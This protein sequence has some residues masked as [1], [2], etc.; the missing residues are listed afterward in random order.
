MKY[1]EDV[2]CKEEMRNAHKSL[3]RKPERGLCID[4]QIILKWIL[5]ECTDVK[6]IPLAL[7]RDQWQVLVTTVMNIM[8]Y[9]K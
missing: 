2:E 7:C 5:R 6:C 3:V 8:F 1:T 4:G 9:K